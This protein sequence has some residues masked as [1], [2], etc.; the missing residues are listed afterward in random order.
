[1]QLRTNDC[2]QISKNFAHRHLLVCSPQ[3]LDIAIKVAKRREFSKAIKSLSLFEDAEDSVTN[4]RIPKLRKLFH[5]LK[6]KA[7]D[8]ELIVT[9]RRASNWRPR[10]ARRRDWYSRQPS[11]QPAGHFPHNGIRDELKRAELWIKTYSTRVDEGP[12]RKELFGATRGE[13]EKWM[14]TLV[15][16]ES[17]ALRGRLGLKSGYELSVL[18]QLPCLRSLCLEGGSFKDLGRD[19]YFTDAYEPFRFPH[20]KKLKLGTWRINLKDL[21][22]FLQQQPVLEH[23][24]LTGA[25]WDTGIGGVLTAIAKPGESF[26]K[27]FKRLTKVEKVIADEQAKIW[28]TRV[29]KGR[30]G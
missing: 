29:I 15:R 20:L 7:D 5:L 28:I 1:M 21:V 8:I 23:V 13:K 6:N 24:D 25:R 10:G 16:V 4:R 30:L 11:S 18:T 26:D 17:L 2:S 12:G 27:L 14:Y 3:D 9:D 19:S 22:V